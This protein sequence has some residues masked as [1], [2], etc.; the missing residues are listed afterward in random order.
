MRRIKP[1]LR[2]ARRL[3]RQYSL[4]ISQEAKATGSLVG[5]V[6][7]VARARLEYGV[8]PL[9][10]S[11]YRFSRV[12]QSEWGDYATDDPILKQRMREMSTPGMLRIAKNKAL[13]YQHCI[14]HGL[15]T[16]P[17]LC[18]IGES[19]D[20]LGPE[21]RCGNDLAEWRAVMQPHRG[22]LFV[23]SVDGTYG[24]G[25]FAVLHLND[26]V[27]QYEGIEGTI[28]DLHC[29]IRSKLG[30]EKGWIVQPRVRVHPQLAGIVSPY[31]LATARIITAMRDGVAR[32]I[33]A[34]F[35]LT[36]GQNTTDN[37]SKGASGNLL[38]GIDLA[39][40]SLSRAWGSRRKDWPEMTGFDTHPETGQKIVGFTLPLWDG[41]VRCALGAQESLPEMRSAGWDIAISDRGVLLVEAN[42]TYDLSIL[43]IAHQRGLKREIFAVLEGSEQSTFNS[44]W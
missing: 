6:Y 34:G 12:P 4:G 29:H 8:G 42:L 43:Q 26:N 31:G 17:V 2:E 21:I 27:Y 36:V 28:D 16:I 37:F 5:G 14:R 20:P 32:V 39:T 25:S 38:S 19:P 22:D 13:M 11:L 24:E 10:Y 44:S 15:P 35:K 30:T 23:K 41:L 33:T 3:A 18:L 40:G 7:R 1:A 9:Y